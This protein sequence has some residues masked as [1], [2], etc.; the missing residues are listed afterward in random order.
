MP[1]AALAGGYLGG[2]LGLVPAMWLGVAVSLL[3]V[4][5]VAFSPLPGM[6]KL[7]DSVVTRSS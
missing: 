6:R 1:L 3:A 2:Q 5:P 4:V 7:P